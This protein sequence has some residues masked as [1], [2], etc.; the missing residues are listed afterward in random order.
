MELLDVDVLI[1]GAGISGIDLAC[2]LGMHCP[3]HTYAILEARDA[4]GGTWDLFR[5]PG[6]R[7]DSDMYTLSFPFRPWTDERSIV[8][9]ASILTYLRET[10]R[11]YAVD[12][13]VHYS[14]RVV[15][16]SFDSTT[17]R[18]SV[19]AST[20]DGPVTHTAAFVYLATGYYSYD[21]GHVVDFPGAADFAGDLVHPQDWP[22]DLDVTGRRV[23]VIGSGATAVTLVPSLVE[24]GAA[25]V[26]MLQRTPSYLAV[27]AARDRAARALRR[28]PEPTRARV[29]RAKSILAS[30]ATYRLCRSLPGV[31]RAALTSTVRR[32][33]PE[34]YPVEE[35]FTPPYDPWD[36][37][38]CVV[39]DGD[40]FAAVSAGDVEVVTDHVER[41]TCD[42]VLLRSGR[43]LPADVLVTATGLTLRVAGS[44]ELSVDG[45]PVRIPEGYVYKGLMLSDVPNL[46][47][48]VGYTNASWTLRADL[49][50]RYVCRLLTHLRERGFDIATPRHTDDAAGSR[51]LLDLSSGYVQR[52]AAQLPRSGARAPWLVR[53]S[54]LV[55]ARAMLRGPV[56]DG[57]LELS[58]ARR[59]RRG[60]GVMDSGARG[61]ETHVT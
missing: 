21:S 50:A 49:S 38:V 17:A 12:E 2:R 53:Q 4:L 44:I 11:A 14:H 27:R 10:A 29:L 47:W 35:H 46:A 41:L 51:P 54:Y 43:E 57:R 31:A 48:C 25:H 40:L 61:D 30:T 22:R 39:P 5:Y 28:L 59:A 18:W 6:I 45:A 26:T 24:A 52:A 36:Q 42:G 15:S 9:G 33:L 3:D 16:A 60:S 8:D 20:P 7:S 37:R 32:C 34:G 23:V 13:R 55:D 19:T 58:R 56:E 1:V